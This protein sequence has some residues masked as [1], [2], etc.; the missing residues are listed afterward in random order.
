M[1]WMRLSRGV[2]T[3]DR[4]RGRMLVLHRDEHRS[5]KLGILRSRLSEAAKLGR[6]MD[7]NIEGKKRKR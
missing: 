1:C 3:Q 5:L 4:G 6:A 7:D 2:W